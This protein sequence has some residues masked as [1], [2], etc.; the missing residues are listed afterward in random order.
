MRICAACG[1]VKVLEDFTHTRGTTYRKKA[2]K[3][4]RAAVAKAAYVPSRPQPQR[5]PPAG[6]ACTECGLTK[7]IDSFTPIRSTQTGVYGRCRECRNAR[8]RE[9]YHSSAEIR[10]A[11]IARALRNKQA[12]KL[13]RRLQPVASVDT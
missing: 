13:R 2:C 6:R 8:A 12:M 9:W 10:A 1:L 5:Q 11:E 7:S 4:C 3:P